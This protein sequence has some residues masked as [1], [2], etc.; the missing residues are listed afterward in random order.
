MFLKEKRRK[1]GE[2]TGKLNVRKLKRGEAR[3]QNLFP[4]PILSVPFYEKKKEK[5]R[6]WAWE[7]TMRKEWSHKRNPEVVAR[8]C[9]WCAV[10]L[11]EERMLKILYIPARRGSSWWVGPNQ[12]TSFPP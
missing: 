6:V 9:C 11:C 8:Y 12:P 4:S 2:H 1:D 10:A 3:G 5:T 7:T